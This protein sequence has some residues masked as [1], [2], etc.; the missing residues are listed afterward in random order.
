MVNQSNRLKLFQTETF[1]DFMNLNFCPW[2][3]TFGA[4]DFLY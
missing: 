2:L 3:S 4:G 1:E